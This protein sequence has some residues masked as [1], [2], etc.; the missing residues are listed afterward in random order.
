MRHGGQGCSWPRGRNRPGTWLLIVPAVGIQYAPWKGVHG[1]NKEPCA[2]PAKDLV[3]GDGGSLYS[4]K[5][6]TPP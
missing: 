3:M 6:K 2:G 1:G 5:G 4:G